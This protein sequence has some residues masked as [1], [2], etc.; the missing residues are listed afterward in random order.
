MNIEKQKEKF[1]RALGISKE[2][3]PEQYKKIYDMLNTQLAAQGLPT[4]KIDLDEY[5]KRAP[6]YVKKIQEVKK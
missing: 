5:K 2:L 1:I 3:H 6:D 4:D